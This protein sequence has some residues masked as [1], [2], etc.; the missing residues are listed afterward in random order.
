MSLVTSGFFFMI[1]AASKEKANIEPSMDDDVLIK[2]V[3]L[4]TLKNI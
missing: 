2:E 1:L 3:C 4:L